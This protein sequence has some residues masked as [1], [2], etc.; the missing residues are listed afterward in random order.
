MTELYDAELSEE[1]YLKL[2]KHRGG[3]TCF[4]SPPCNNCCEPCTVEEAEILCFSPVI[5]YD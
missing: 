3:C 4:I 2:I 5:T 1:Q